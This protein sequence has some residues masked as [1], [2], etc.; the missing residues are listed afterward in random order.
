LSGAFGLSLWDCP[1]VE[2]VI[3][4]NLTYDRTEFGR[5]RQVE[6]HDLQGKRI[7]KVS[8]QET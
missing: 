8:K 4:D 3:T 6:R 5:V 7:L 1:V 2:R